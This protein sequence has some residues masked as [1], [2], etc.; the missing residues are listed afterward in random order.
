MT[1]LK[2]VGLLVLV[3]GAFVALGFALVGLQD[4]Y[5]GRHQ[6]LPFFLYAIASLLIVGFT[7]NVSKRILL[8]AARELHEPPHDQKAEALQKSASQD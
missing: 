1:R 4:K 5:I 8:S 2:F 3:L 7:A 6:G